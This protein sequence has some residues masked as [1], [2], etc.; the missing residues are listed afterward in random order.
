M[1]CT[2]FNPHMGCEDIPANYLT[3]TWGLVPSGNHTNLEGTQGDFAVVENGET[4]DNDNL[5][6][7]SIVLP[8]IKELSER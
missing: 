1:H 5:A 7:W 2:V 4:Q 6:S 8:K 3:V